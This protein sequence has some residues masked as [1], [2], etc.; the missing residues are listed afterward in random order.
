MVIKISVVRHLDD[1]D[2]SNSTMSPE[3]LMEIMP[4]GGSAGLSAYE[5]A[6]SNGFIG[7]ENEWLDSLKGADAEITN[8]NVNAAIAEDPEATR[9]ML[10]VGSGSSSV[11]PDDVGFDIW[12]RAGQSNGQNFGNGYAAALDHTDPRVYRWDGHS[13]QTYYQIPT[14]YTEPHQTIDSS[15]PISGRTGT[16]FGSS[17]GRLYASSISSNRKVMIVDC[18]V[19]ST[20]L[21]GD[22]WAAPSGSL[23]LNAITQANAAVASGQN[24]RFAG[25]LWCQGEFDAYNGVKSGAYNTAL[26]AVFSGLRAGITGASEAPIIVIGMVPDWRTDPSV[27]L[28]P[29]VNDV[30]EI[31]KSHATSPYRLPYTAFVDGPTGYTNNPSTT[32]RIH[33][34]SAG[35]LIIGKDIFYTG[36]PQAKVSTPASFSTPTIPTLDA[37]STTGTTATLTITAPSNTGYCKL[38]YRLQ[39]NGTWTDVTDIGSMLSRLL[40]GLTL[41]ATYEAQAA[42]G[43]YAGESGWTSSVVWQQ[44]SLPDTASVSITDT[45]T[46]SI[47]ASATSTGSTSFEWRY[48]AVGAG[49]YTTVTGQ[50]GST[51][52][53]GSLSAGDYLISARGVNSYG[54]GPWSSD[55]SA[56][57]GS[58]PSI[59]GQAFGIPDWNNGKIILLYSLSGGT[60]GNVTFEQRNAGSGSYSSVTPDSAT[61][62]RAVLPIS[63]SSADKDIQIVG[64]NTVTLT[65]LAVAQPLHNLDLNNLTGTSQVTSAPNLGTDATAWTQS[66]G[67]TCMSQNTSLISGKVVLAC[68]ESQR[69]KVAASLPASAYTTLVVAR[70][71][72]F[73][74]YGNYISEYGSTPTRAWWRWAYTGSSPP[75]TANSAKVY[76]SH[77]PADNNFGPSP[78]SGDMSTNAWY[79][80]GATFDGVNTLK[81]YMNGNLEYTKT[82]MPTRTTTSGGGMNLN[83]YNDLANS[84]NNGYYAGAFIWGTALTAAQI[85]QIGEAVRSD[86]GITFG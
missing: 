20:A 12:L 64:S 82:D 63:P 86:F 67:S 34:S 11:D 54:N 52:T 14:L 70:H 62:T 72:N 2:S 38:R 22:V 4:G 25:I 15:G 83:G 78:A 30:L 17:F 41:G 75:G 43:N 51:V 59:S 74:G 37:V 71:S 65:W 66:A 79:A 50:T 84:G 33:Y 31:H 28:N 48:K 46:N 76:T 19:G 7:N 9:S 80:L 35:H 49:S 26:D 5:I 77:A 32:E 18:N 45:T 24:N 42:V 55:Q 68:T 57:V 85:Q 13:S 47:S 10:G 6:V 53:I 39:G 36:L 16:G 27:S 1:G 8:T 23:Y 44:V 58:V 21:V 3:E 60:I 56:S 29:T 69:L 40:T 73:S 81:E 61:S